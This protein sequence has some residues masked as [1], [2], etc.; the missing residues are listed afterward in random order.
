MN[1][2]DMHTR[3]NV[4]TATSRDLA[5]E[6]IRLTLVALD[7]TSPS[8]CAAARQGERILD[9]VLL[10]P[11]QLGA[12]ASEAVRIG[13]RPLVDAA[14]LRSIRQ[15]W[16]RCAEEG[17]YDYHRIDDALVELARASDAEPTRAEVGGL[18]SLL[19]SELNMQRRRAG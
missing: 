3:P 18:L 13:R 9:G 19:R 1:T 8:K 4:T 16:V 14:T 5:G 10:S 6:L 11:R 12:A 7:D 2:P 15:W 17:W